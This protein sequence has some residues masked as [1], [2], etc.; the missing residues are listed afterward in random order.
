MV[1]LL[2]YLKSQ[3]KEIVVVTIPVP[4]CLKKMPK[5]RRTLQ[6]YNEWLLT[7]KFPKM[8]K[9][10]HLSQGDAMSARVLLLLLELKTGMPQECFVL[11]RL[12]TRPCIYIRDFDARA[13]DKN[14]I[15]RSRLQRA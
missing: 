11:L 2:D 5:P 8:R 7:L 10:I 9:F 3:T 6:N 13:T 4:P 12:F 15:I 14:A 1:E